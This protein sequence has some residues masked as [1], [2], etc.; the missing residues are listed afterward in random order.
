MALD[1]EFIQLCSLRPHNKPFISLNPMDLCCSVTV[2]GKV[3]TSNPDVGIDLPRIFLHLH[4]LLALL[5][6]EAPATGF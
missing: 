1:H 3:V 4:W 2:S 5:A 6:D